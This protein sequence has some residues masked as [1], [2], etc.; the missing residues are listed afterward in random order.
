M[1]KI[2]PQE[3]QVLDEHFLRCHFD[4]A[5]YAATNHKIQDEN[6]ELVSFVLNDEQ[7][8]LEEIWLD[9]EQSGRL[10]RMYVLKGRKQGV[11]TWFTSRSHWMITAKGRFKEGP[12]STEF[13]GLVKNQNMSVIAHDP[14]T[15]AYLFEMCKRIDE[16]VQPELA[17]KK[18]KNNGYLI[19]FKD[20]ENPKNPDSL[21]S[22][23]S[24]GSADTKD[25]GS[26]MTLTISIDQSLPS[27]LQ[28]I[29][30][31]F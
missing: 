17:Q 10:V 12:T 22:T 3:Q 5:Y 6:N 26:G 4:Y 18:T 9:I 8:I 24:V 15:T 19:H 27:G 30:R 21:D 29:S 16:N 28:R 7:A 14:K 23:I 20:D 1:A 25:F 2:T 31:A 11:S 13:I